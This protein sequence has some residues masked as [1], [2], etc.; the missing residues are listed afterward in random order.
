MYGWGLLLRRLSHLPVVPVV[1]KALVYDEKR[2][3][4]SVGMWD[5]QCRYVGHTVSVCGTY[6]VGM[7]DIQCR[8]VGHTVSVCGTYSVGMWDIQ[9]RYVGHTVS[10][11]GTYSVGM[12]DIQCR[13]V[14]CVREVMSE[15]RACNECWCIG[16]SNV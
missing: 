14:G 5:I 15:C 12:W 2:G 6:S 13:Y 8:Y 11:C 1:L 10:V 4:Y 9:C 7:W 16:H 3:T